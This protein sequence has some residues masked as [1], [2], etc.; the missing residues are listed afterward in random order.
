MTS[1]VPDFLLIGSLL[2]NI[3]WLIL[4][5][6]LYRLYAETS[7]QRLGLLRNLVFFYR[8]SKRLNDELNRQKHETTEQR[9]T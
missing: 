6:M 7:R 5:V 2:I 9:N 1:N 4:F 3:F 8:A